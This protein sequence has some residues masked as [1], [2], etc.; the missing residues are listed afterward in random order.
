[1]FFFTVSTWLFYTTVISVIR[2]E[3]VVEVQEE[4]TTFWLNGSAAATEVF[5]VDPLAAHALRLVV[6]ERN[7]MAIEK[8]KTLAVTKVVYNSWFSECVMPD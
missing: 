7:V 1:M 2:P 4:Q 6:G 8:L 3:D 5:K